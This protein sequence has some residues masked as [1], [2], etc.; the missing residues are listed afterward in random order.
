MENTYGFTTTANDEYYDRVLA[1]ASPETN[2]IIATERNTVTGDGQN[3][4]TMFV[5]KRVFVFGLLIPDATIAGT[6]LFELL[7]GAAEDY[8][9]NG[10]ETD[11]VGDE[12]SQ[13]V[14]YSDDVPAELETLRHEIRRIDNVLNGR[15]L[16]VTV[17]SY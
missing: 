9:D 5:R 11:Q 15:V 10:S 14:V 1:E 17:E 8:R 12:W 6:P 2:F 16:R 3:F 4:V 7:V 13:V